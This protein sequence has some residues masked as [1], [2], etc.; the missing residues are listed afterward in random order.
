MNMNTCCEGQGTRLLG[1]MPEFIYSIARD[2]L[3]VNLF[4]ASSITWRHDSKSLG[5]TMASGF[6][7]RPDVEL[8]LS[9]AVPVRARIRVRVPAWAARQMPI[10]VNGATAAVGAAGS[11]A[12]LDREW[13][14]GDTISFTLPMDFR[15]TRYT[16]QD[17]V[18]GQ[19]RYALEY[20]PLLMALVGGVGEKGEALL[21][22]A[23]QELLK[24]LQPKIGEPLHFTIAGEAGREYMPYWQV[25]D[26]LFTCYPVMGAR[27]NG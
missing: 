24:A 10:R 1:A 15:L 12:V 7:L 4:E 11:Y 22:P 17:R 5:L 25:T 2:G 9:A 27:E 6:P 26:Q 19:E 21:A 3:Y 14:D 13:N 20:G 16:G 23:P 18:A 8:H